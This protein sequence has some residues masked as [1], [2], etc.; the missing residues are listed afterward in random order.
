MTEKTKKYFSDVVMA[1]N[2]ISEFTTETKDFN[3]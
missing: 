2:L 3:S 1:I